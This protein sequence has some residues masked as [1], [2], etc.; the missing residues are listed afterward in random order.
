LNRLAAA[1]AL[2][3]EG[4]TPP[5]VDQPHLYAVRSAIVNLP[6]EANWVEQTRD[7]VRAFTDL[8]VAALR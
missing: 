6:R 3:R 1:K 7:V 5:G 4:L 2:Q 8:P